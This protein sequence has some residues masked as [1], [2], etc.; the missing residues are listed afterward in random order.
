MNKIVVRILL[1]CANL[2]RYKIKGNTFS[3]LWQ[4]ALAKRDD[5]ESVTIKKDFAFFKHF[6]VIN[7]SLV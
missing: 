5:S 4:G 3:C 1:S 6:V 2:L 7:I